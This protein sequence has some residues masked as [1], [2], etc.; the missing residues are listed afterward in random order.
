[1]TIQD[2][3]AIGEILGAIATIATLVYLATQVRQNTQALQAASMDST[4]KTANEI[5]ASLFGD[6]EITNIYFSGLSDV[7]S[8]SE[9]DRE[10]FR[11]IMTNALWAFWNTY[12]Q[13]QLG[14]KQSWSSQRKI[15]RRFLSQPGGV[16]F[17]EKYGN[18]FS[19]DFQ[20]EIS[21][22]LKD[23]RDTLPPNTGS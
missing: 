7:S 21:Q 14:G 13:A 19:P 4:T 3:G 17:W 9:I 22:I 11:L 23:A 16:W 8:L 6:P 15:I 18:E 5:R 1:M 12:S 2:W 20:K 10:R